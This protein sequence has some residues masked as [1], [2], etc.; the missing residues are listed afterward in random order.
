MVLSESQ[1]PKKG[2]IGMKGNQ[3]QPILKSQIITTES[4]CNI[5]AIKCAKDLFPMRHI[6]KS[7]KLSLQSEASIP[8]KS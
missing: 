4:L 6:I 1:S 7:S 8:T 5:K 2:P 3:L